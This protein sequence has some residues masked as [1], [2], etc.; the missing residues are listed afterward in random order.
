MNYETSNLLSS[1]VTRFP[2][3]ETLMIEA[4]YGGKDNILP[5]AKEEDEELPEAA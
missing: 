1:A 2:R 3:L 4:T 5:S